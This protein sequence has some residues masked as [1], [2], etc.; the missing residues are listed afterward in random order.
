MSKM[1]VKVAVV[2]DQQLFR[3]GMVA[4]VK[5]VS[6]MDVII[7]SANGKEFIEALKTKR[8]D[9][10]LLD[11]KMPEMDGMEV[12]EYLNQK[13]PDIKIIILTMHDEDEL[14]FHLAQKGA[15]GF[16][17][18][19]SDME[20]VTDAIYTV[21]A[22][23][24]YFKENIMDKLLKAMTRNHKLTNPPNP[25]ENALTERELEILK[26]ICKEYTT[27]EISE[28]LSVSKRT[29]DGHRERICQKINVRNVAGMIKYAIK[30][31]LLE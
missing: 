22:G 11:V 24:R 26:L 8:P 28:A 19:N 25:D 10:V 3:Q 13:H 4:L 5:D 18:K 15:H 16:L 12:T 1:K 23:K 17:F 30:N 9:V 2:D 14:I 20:T 6:E 31:N 27:R 7:E 29:V 21:M